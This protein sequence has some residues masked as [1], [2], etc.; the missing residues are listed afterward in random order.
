M[1]KLLN[2]K[3][4]FIQI[5]NLHYNKLEKIIKIPNCKACINYDDGFCSKYKINNNYFTSDYTSLTC[6]VV[7]EDEKKCGLNGKDFEYNIKQQNK[8]KTSLT[9]LGSLA[10]GFPFIGLLTFYQPVFSLIIKFSG[11][12]ILTMFYK[13]YKLEILKENPPYIEYKKNDK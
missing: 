11:L 3:N 9:I 12:C 13:F 5:R 8:I 1:L 10:I 6:K 2:N 7:R 4:L